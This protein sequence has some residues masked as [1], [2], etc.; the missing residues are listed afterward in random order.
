MRMKMSI[1]NDDLHDQRQGDENH[2]PQREPQQGPRSQA[3]NRHRALPPPRPVGLKASVKQQH[4]EHHDQ[5]GIGA[6]E[7]DAERFRDAHHQACDQR[8]DHVA[9]RAEHH[10]DK[11]HQHEGLADERIGRI[12]RHQQRAGGTRQRQCDAERDAEHAV[13]IDPHQHGD[14]AVLRRRAHRLAEI[15]GVQEHPERAA[16]RHRDHEGDQLGDGDIEPAEMEGFIRIGGVNG[17]VIRAEQHQRQI[18][19]AAATARR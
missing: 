11:G 6:D 14:V 15:G 4:R 1:A 5:P 8:A 16:Q 13:G 10:R 7:L 2:S 19:A 3:Q 9:E 12:E 18:Q 17:A